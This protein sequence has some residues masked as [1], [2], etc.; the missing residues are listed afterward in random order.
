[1]LDQLIQ[2][3]LRLFHLINVEWSNNALDIILPWLR[4]KYVWAP[5]YVF[6]GSFILYN[7]GRKGVLICI[8]L[9]VTVLA[10][11]QISSDIIKGIFVRPRPCHYPELLNQMN[12]LVSCGSGYSFVSSHAANHFGVAFFLGFLFWRKSRIILPLGLLWAIIISYSQI[13]V[14]VHFPFDVAGGALLGTAIGSG[15]VLLC[16]RHLKDDF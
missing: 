13:Y 10:C 3:D 16:I 6:I 4:N 8:Y 2:L 1:M 5:L 14:G 15:L 9:A 11:D 7:Y 12:L